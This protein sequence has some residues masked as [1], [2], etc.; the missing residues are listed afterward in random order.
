MPRRRKHENNGPSSRNMEIYALVCAGEQTN[1]E[2]GEQYGICKQRVHQIRQQ[3]EEWSRPQWQGKIDV[4][5]DKQTKLLMHL[6]QEAMT[7]WERSKENAVKYSQQKGGKEAGKKTRSIGGQCGDP[8]YLDQAR[9]CLADIRK[10]WGA[11]AQPDINS[12]TTVNV[13]MNVLA[14]AP[15]DER[16]RRLAAI[17]DGLRI[18]AMAEGIGGFEGGGRG[19]AVGDPQDADR[20]GDGEPLRVCETGVV[21]RRTGD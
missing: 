12:E 17:A 19:E 20:A 15:P 13:Q 10:I 14:N 16:G 7:E 4:I 6:F 1:E 18:E 5:K 21:D 3:V 8:R 9:Q 2:I 11:N